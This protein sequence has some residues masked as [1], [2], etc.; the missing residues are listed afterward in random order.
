MPNTPP[1]RP[2][3][4]IA[5]IEVSI[6]FSTPKASIIGRRVTAKPVTVQLGIGVT[7]PFQ[8]RSFFWRSSSL[9]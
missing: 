4:L 8:P 7:N 9:A 2:A 1:L 5:C 3:P 6:T